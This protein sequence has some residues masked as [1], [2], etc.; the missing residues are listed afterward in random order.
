MILAGVFN[1][2]NIQNLLFLFCGNF[3][4]RGKS[5][6]HHRN[7][8]FRN[9]PVLHQILPGGFTDGNDF[10]R[11]PDKMRQDLLDIKHS[12]PVILYRHMVLG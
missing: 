11:F 12:E 4:R 8:F 3:F 1:A 6:I 7:L 2:G 10:L 9:M 5:I